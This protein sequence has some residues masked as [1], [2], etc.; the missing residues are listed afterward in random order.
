MV[1]LFPLFPYSI[2][3]WYGV[4]VVNIKIRVVTA[5]FHTMSIFAIGMRKC[6]TLEN[7][8]KAPFFSVFLG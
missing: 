5:F 1:L 2:I 3:Y 4:Y 6:N 7:L 8:L